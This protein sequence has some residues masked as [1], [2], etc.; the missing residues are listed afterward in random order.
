LSTPSNS[1]AVETVRAEIK[2]S[3]AWTGEAVPL[4]ITLYSPGPFSGTAAFDLP[5]LPRTA[6]VKGGS[7]VVSSEEVDG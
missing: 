2:K 1:A 6:F 3:S 4:I 5:D 7:P